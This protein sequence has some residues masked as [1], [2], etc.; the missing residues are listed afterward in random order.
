MRIVLGVR[1]LSKYIKD[2]ELGPDQRIFP[3]T[4][5]AA[6]VM[7]NRAG[8]MVDIHLKPH[9]PRRHAATF[10]SREGTPFE[11]VRHSNDLKW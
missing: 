7:V 10:A 1:N 2:K 6:R 3:I 8:K 5:F 4:D 11:I 9:D